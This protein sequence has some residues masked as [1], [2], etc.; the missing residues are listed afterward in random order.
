MDSAR[1]GDQQVPQAPV[2][3]TQVDTITRLRRAA[4]ADKCFEGTTVERD[5]QT[6]S[7]ASPACVAKLKKTSAT[8]SDEFFSVME[9]AQTA[10]LLSPQT[11]R[12][13]KNYPSGAKAFR[14]A[15]IAHPRF[16]TTRTPA[17]TFGAAN[18]D[19]ATTPQ[20][21]LHRLYSSTSPR[22]SWSTLCP[23]VP[24]PET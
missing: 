13:L 16:S 18:L 21:L 24:P 5:V 23:Q 10:L 6:A 17:E 2:V 7:G 4:Q 20:S 12:A 22:F 8:P 19:K 14:A 9:C 3:E 1:L 11:R 15:T